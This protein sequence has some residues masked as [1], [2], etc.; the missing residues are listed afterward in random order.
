MTRT[1]HCDCEWKSPTSGTL[2]VS[3]GVQTSSQPDVG[4]NPC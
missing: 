4:V 1:A 2:I 3:S